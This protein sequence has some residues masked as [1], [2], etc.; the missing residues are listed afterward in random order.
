[1][2]RAPMAPST[3]RPSACAHTAPNMPV[4]APMTA[5]GLPRKTFSASGR[6]AQSSAFLSCPGSEWLYSGVEIR[7]ASASAMA[8]RRWAT[9]SGAGATSSSSL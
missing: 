7:T 8:A 3:L 4:L 2:T 5:T 1:M 9:A 6:E